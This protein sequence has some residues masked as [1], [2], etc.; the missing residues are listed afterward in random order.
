MAFETVGVLRLR[1]PSNISFWLCIGRLSAMRVPAVVVKHRLAP[2]RSAQL[3]T[4]FYFALC[5]RPEVAKLRDHE[6]AIDRR[7]AGYA[8][9]NPNCLR[10]VS[11]AGLPSRRPARRWRVGL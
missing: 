5:S 4:G 2:S 11:R 9:D 8:V 10:R 7:K 6:I 3:G 1:K